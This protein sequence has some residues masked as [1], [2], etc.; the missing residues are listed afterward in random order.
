MSPRFGKISKLQR[1]VF[2]T[3]EAT[4]VMKCFS[5]TQ[6]CAEGHSDVE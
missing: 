5:V 2:E 3:F 1:R 4:N 6:G